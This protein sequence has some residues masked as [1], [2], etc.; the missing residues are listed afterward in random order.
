MTEQDRDIICRNIISIMCR[1]VSFGPSKT[2]LKVLAVTPDFTKAL[3]KVPGHTDWSGIGS[4]S[5]Y[6]PN[7]QLWELKSDRPGYSRTREVMEVTR[8]NRLTTKKLIELMAE[9]LKPIGYTYEGML[10]LNAS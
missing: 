7:I 8:S 3:V 5:Y 9:H 4:R 2:R 6:S 10:E 1:G